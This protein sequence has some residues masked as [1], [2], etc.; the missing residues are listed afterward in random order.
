M[1]YIII[2]VL[3]TIVIILVA[4]IVLTTLKL[5]HSLHSMQKNRIF[6]HPTDRQVIEN[7][8]PR[9]IINYSL[10]PNELNLIEVGAG[11]CAVIIKA[12]HLYTWQSMLAIEVESIVY[13]WGKFL[14]KIKGLDK[15]IVYIKSNCIDYVYPTNSLI[16]CYMGRDIMKSMYNNKRFEGQFVISL[17]FPIEGVVET[18]KITLDTYQKC[19]YIYDF[20]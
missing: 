5:I 3:I 7:H 1:N 2:L 6:F 17:T 12:S 4:L 9:I 15:K 10:K 13:L 19:I 16:Y 14:L 11:D 8:L 20:R 18:E